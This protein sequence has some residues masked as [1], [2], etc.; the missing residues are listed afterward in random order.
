MSGVPTK[1]K[2]KETIMNTTDIQN[3]RSI[4]IERQIKIEYREWLEDVGK[5]RSPENAQ[6][7]AIEKIHISGG[8]DYM[9]KKDREIISFLENE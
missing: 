1:E 3:A 4:V 7:F 6:L 2:S 8:Y 9:G 5:E